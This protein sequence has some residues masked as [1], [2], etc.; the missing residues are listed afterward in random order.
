MGNIKRLYEDLC[1]CYIRGY[2]GIIEGWGCFIRL[3][4]GAI[5]GLG[6]FSEKVRLGFK[7]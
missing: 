2:I 6:C 4:E 7:F 5:W 3:I 1:K